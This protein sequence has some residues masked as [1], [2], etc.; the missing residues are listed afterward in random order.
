MFHILSAWKP[1]L[2]ETLGSVW[3]DGIVCLEQRNWSVSRVNQFDND[4]YVCMSIFYTLYLGD[5]RSEVY[6]YRSP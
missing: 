6:T 4:H 5:L 2:T 3:K 1:K